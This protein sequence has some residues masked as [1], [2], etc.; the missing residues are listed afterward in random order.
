L[1]KLS[2]DDLILLRTERKSSKRLQGGPMVSCKLDTS[3][4]Q[5][6]HG[7]SV[8]AQVLSTSNQT[9]GKSSHFK[10]QHTDMRSLINNTHF[11]ETLVS[12]IKKEV[13]DELVQKQLKEI[14]IDPRNKAS[15]LRRNSA[16]RKIQEMQEQHW[17][18]F[19]KRSQSVLLPALSTRSY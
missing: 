11:K 13:L 4:G 5:V 1:D 17:T 14:K 7:Y 16:L 6:K 3:T 8:P 15:E 10:R 12:K 9:Y 18:N 2:F 19:E